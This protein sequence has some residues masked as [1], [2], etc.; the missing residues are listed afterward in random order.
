MLNEFAKVYLATLSGKD[1]SIRSAI[2]KSYLDQ[3]P[4]DDKRMAIQL[5]N[6]YKFIV[7]VKRAELTQ[8][9][10]EYKDLPDWLIRESH[11]VTGDWAETF[12]LII[13]NPTIRTSGFSLSGFVTQLLEPKPSKKE[14]REWVESMWSALS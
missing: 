12:A 11:V 6:G 14:L 1:Q 4:D 8:W 5:L 10:M 13:G 7:Q 9:L 3:A 2:L